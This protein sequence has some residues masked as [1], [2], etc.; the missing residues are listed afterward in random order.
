MGSFVDSLVC[1][2][3]G[4]K[5]DFDEDKLHE[6]H[7]ELSE[8]LHDRDAQIR[9]EPATVEFSHF[10]LIELDLLNEDQEIPADLQQDIL[11]SLDAMGLEALECLERAKSFRSE[12]MSSDIS[13]GAADRAKGM[14]DPDDQFYARA[15]AVFENTM[16]AP[17]GKR[18]KFE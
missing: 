17:G 2:A 6:I 7:H 3:R 8:I 13:D 9:F 18:L 11:G 4:A 12:S 15:K 1:V 16:N 10:G 5:K 14:I